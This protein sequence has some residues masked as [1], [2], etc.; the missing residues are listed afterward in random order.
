MT[1]RVFVDA[2]I[3]VSRTIMDWLFHLRCVNEGMFQ[4]HSTDDV[5]VEAL[6]A[7]RDRNPRA[8]GTLLAER[9]SKIRD[10]V[11]EVVPTFP[12]NLS[13]TG[14]DEGNYHVH[15]AAITSRADIILTQNKPED[16][17]QNPDDEPY[18][19]YSADDFFM[20]VVQSNPGCLLPCTRKQL[21]FWGSRG[22]GQLDDR[23]KKADCPTFA[24]EIRRAL[25]RLAMAP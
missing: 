1:Q 12:G 20:L 17:T 3:F 22:K 18:E 2:N 6:A 25:Q 21:A 11:D 4:L 8:S 10:C 14:A 24:E 23:L 9:M 15:A 5:F 19:I 13:F 7:T 16:I